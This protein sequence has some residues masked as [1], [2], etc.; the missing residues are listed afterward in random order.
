LIQKLD[1]VAY[2][3]VVYTGTVSVKLQHSIKKIDSDY[4]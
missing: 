2:I 1:C 3:T 4:L